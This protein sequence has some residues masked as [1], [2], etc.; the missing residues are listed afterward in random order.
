MTKYLPILLLLAYV[1]ETYRPANLLKLFG[2]EYVFRL[3][4][5]APLT[6]AIR[7]Q[8][9]RVDATFLRYLSA[10]GRDWEPSVSS[11]TFCA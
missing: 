4:H 7:S 6:L 11:I 10:Y 1:N 5:F 3:G 8:A 9:R 2:R